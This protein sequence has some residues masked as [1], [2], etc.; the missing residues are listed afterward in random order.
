M[1][2]EIHHEGTYLR[3]TYDVQGEG[4]ALPLRFSGSYAT[5]GWDIPNYWAIDATGQA[6]QDVGGHGGGLKRCNLREMLGNMETDAPDTNEWVRRNLDML[7][8]MPEWMRTA[9]AAGWTP[10]PGFD[11]GLY[12]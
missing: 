2:T 6:W 12:E 11:R 9:I 4:P 3:F 1:N 10:P 7:P 5:M 8:V